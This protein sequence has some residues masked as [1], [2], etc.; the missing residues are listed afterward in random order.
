MRTIIMSAFLAVAGNASA[1][2]FVSDIS[3]RFA[4][5]LQTITTGAAPDMLTAIAEFD[6]AGKVRVVQGRAPVLSNFGPDF[7]VFK[8]SG[9][10]SYGVNR[11]CAGY[12]ILNLNATT[13]KLPAAQVRAQVVLN[14][15]LQTL[16]MSGSV[17]L[18]D[19]YAEESQPD[20]PDRF[21]PANTPYGEEVAGTV[22]F[23]K[24]PL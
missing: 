18:E 9:S 2:C 12:A 20:I 10:G 16:E 4:M 13:Y 23:S 24:I 22:T 8:I 14:G 6:G 17:I 19:T 1:D 5:T 7:E 3:G 11:A 21:F 15:Q